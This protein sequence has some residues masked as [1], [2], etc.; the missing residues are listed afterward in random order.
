MKLFHAL[1]SMALLSNPTRCIAQESNK[2]S[3]EVGRRRNAVGDFDEFN[4]IFENASI[5]MP[6]S[7]QVSERVALIDFDMT[8]ENIKCYNIS[9]GDIAIT[10]NRVSDQSIDVSVGVY[11]LDLNCELDY[12]YKY[13]LLR[14]DGWLKLTTEN[15]WAFTRLNFE[16]EDFDSLPPSSSSVKSCLTDIEIENMDFEGDLVSEIIEIFQRLVRGTVERAIGNVACDE[17]G[18]IGTTFFE[19]MIELADEKLEPYLAELGDDLTDPLYMERT[20]DLPQNLKALDLQ[21]NEDNAVGKLFQQVLQGADAFLGTFISDSSSSSNERDLAINIFLR[22]NLLDEDRSLTIDVSELPIDTP[23]IFKGHDRIIETTMT[24]N[25]VKIF[26]IDSLSRFNPFVTIGKH[27]L[28]NELT[29]DRLTVE[30]DVTVDMKPSTLEDAI[31]QDPTSPGIS[32]RILV[33][34]GID[35]LDVLASLLLLINEETLGSLELGQLLHSDHFLPCLLSVIHE[36]QL[37][38]LKVDPKII[39][40]PNLDGFISPGVDRMVSDSATAAFEMYTGVLKQAIPNI[41]E[42]NVRDFMNTHV[43]DAYFSDADTTC[44]PVVSVG[45]LVN[46]QELFGEEYNTYGDLP[47][48]LKNL[49]DSELLVVDETTG[50]PRINEVLVAPFTEMQSGVEG[51]LAFFGDLFGLHSETIPQIG[52]DSIELKAFDASIENLDTLGAPIELLKPNATNGF[53]LDNMARIGT[54]ANPMRFALKGLLA[55]KGDP[56]LE[57]RNEVDVSVEIEES[58]VFASI[59]AK[60]DSE[61]FSTFPLRDIVNLECWL[62]TLAKPLMEGAGDLVD[63]N[64]VALALESILLSIPSMKFDFACTNCTSAGLDVI[65]EILTL[66]ESNGISDVL[67]QRLVKVGLDLVQSDYVQAYL[68]RMVIEGSLRCPHSPHFQG[69]SASSDFPVPSYPTLPYDSLESVVFASTLLLQ[70]ATVVV[71][72]SHKAFEVGSGDPLSG[73]QE[74]SVDSSVDLFDFTS[75]AISLGEWVDIGLEEAMGYLSNVVDDPNGVNGKDLRIN[76]IVRST[77]LDENR[78]M[79]I[80]FND[81]SFGGDDME[82]ALKHV[83]VVG[84]DT[85]SE[86]NAMEILAP[87]TLS[88]KIKW[89]NLGVEIV[90]TVLGNEWHKSKEDISLY[91][92]LSDVDISAALLLALDVELAGSLQ[93]SSILEVQNILPCL[94]STAQAAE[95]TELQVAIGSIGDFYV[96]GFKSSELQEASTTTSRLVME[97]FGDD[98]LASMPAI[99]DVTIRTMLNNWIDFYR[100]DDVAC[101]IS[102]FESSS[103]GF[104]DFRDLFLS[105]ATSRLLGGSGSMPYGDLFS[106]GLGFVQDLFFNVKESTGLSKLNDLLITPLTESQS[107]EAGSLVFSGDLFST[108]SRVKVG[109]LDT[110]I[111]LKASNARIDN[112]N[113]VGAPLAFLEAIDGEAHQL[114]NTATLGVNDR[115]LSFAVRFLISLLGDGKFL[116]F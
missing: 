92:E 70:M 4:E 64:D 29:W 108:D 76:G 95:L 14:G 93:L 18:S 58:E 47:P 97:T 15:N 72:E 8:I 40:E 102:S 103:Q 45:G 86:L 81:I 109:G 77:L 84:L 74:L 57:T 27:T 44:P 53:V 1:A 112:L 26:G 19:G 85:I 10:H 36:V 105:A 116:R 83:R 37:S 35:N 113:T 49:F 9:V 56:V 90:I 17:L 104:V 21:D 24:L 91:L 63:P 110:T 67:E 69:E 79:N 48:M 62:A 3:Q 42:S 114:N 66:L 55:L 68:N 52:M 50:M 100:T 23:V 60:I 39:N 80:G 2:K 28:Q 71:A 115:P 34:F 6:D 30:F 107:N 22:D 88:N 106:T 16:S 20:V 33:D 41:F 54:E 61:A 7:Y 43:I 82:V 87:Q 13:G 25:Q 78:L 51:T 32:E 111:E 31:L 65:P 38:G 94:L 89:K 101:P 96:N 99:F 75:L 73:Q 11:Q 12:S 59:L 46:F 98:I 5:V